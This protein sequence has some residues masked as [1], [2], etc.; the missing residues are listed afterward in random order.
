MNAV[1]RERWTE[2]EIDALPIGEHDFSRSQ[3]AVSC[4]LT[5]KPYRL[6]SAKALWAFAN[7]GGGHLILGVGN[8]G[9]PDGVPQTEGKTPVREWLEQKDS[10]PR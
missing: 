4:S 2:A 7:S 6:H 9:Q 1:K 5:K 8:T 10:A 3:R